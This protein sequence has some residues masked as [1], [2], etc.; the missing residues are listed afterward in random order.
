MMRCVQGYMRII[1]NMWMGEEMRKMLI[2]WFVINQ[3]IIV[4][5]IKSQCIKVYMVIVVS[6]FYWDRKMLRD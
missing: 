6:K 4:F 5:M 3:V 1:E 2:W